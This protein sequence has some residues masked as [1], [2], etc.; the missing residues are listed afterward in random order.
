MS[1]IEITRI[2]TVIIA[3]IYFILMSLVSMRFFVVKDSG[4]AL[5]KRLISTVVGCLAF[6]VL[7]LLASRPINSKI[8]LLLAIVL[9]LYAI[10]IFYWAW[11][12]NK[13]KP[14]SFVFSIELPT[15][16]VQG[17]PYQIVRHPFYSSY[18]ACWLAS[19]VATQ[20]FGVAAMSVFLIGTYTI[21]AR[22]EESQFLSNEL[23]QAY[24]AYSSRTGMLIPN[25]LRITA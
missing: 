14:L 5:G 2:S 24:R 8:A 11:Q 19:T 16:I 4:A 10:L 3:A 25:L 21:A 18:C 20:N 17:G 1:S 9:Y 15:H 6:V 23:A 7:W 13:S 22:R 12:I